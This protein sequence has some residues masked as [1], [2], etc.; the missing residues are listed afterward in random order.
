MV[1]FNKAFYNL[2][3]KRAKSRNTLAK[4]WSSFIMHRVFEDFLK[5]CFIDGKKKLLVFN[6]EQKL[7]INPSLDIKQRQ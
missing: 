3:I 6:G 7:N 5:S 2:S 1:N 4:Y